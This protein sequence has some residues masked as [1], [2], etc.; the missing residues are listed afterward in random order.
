MDP[1]SAAKSGHERNEL[2]PLETLPMW[3]QGLEGLINSDEPIEIY[4]LSGS[5]P[6]DKGRVSTT[7][8]M[9]IP[10]GHRCLF[11]HHLS[12]HQRTN[13]TQNQQ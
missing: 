7:G 11:R 1:A 12:F 8:L 13:V 6:N 5:H 9:I 3:A 2:V 10:S 4:F